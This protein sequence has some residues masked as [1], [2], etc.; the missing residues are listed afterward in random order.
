MNVLI[1]SK[2][3]LLEL[4]GISQNSQ[5]FLK[6]KTFP[7]IIVELSNCLMPEI[8]GRTNESHLSGH[9]TYIIIIQYLYAFGI[10]QLFKNRGNGL[11]K[12]LFDMVN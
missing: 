9:N 10:L 11:M 1:V 5:N 12:I 7:Q 8:V 3:S 2:W 4:L 6:T